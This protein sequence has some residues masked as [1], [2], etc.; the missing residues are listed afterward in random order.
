MGIRRLCVSGGAALREETSVPAPGV[1]RA[2]PFG[3]SLA[4][5]GV[6][7]IA[8]LSVLWLLLVP[9]TAFGDS[10]PN[11]SLRFGPSANLPDC[12]AYE[13]VSPAVK[14]DNS[15]LFEIHGFADGEHV[16][17]GSVLP[18]PGAQS[19][20]EGE[21]LSSRTPQ[22]WI[23]TPLS[24]PAGPGEPYG[25]NSGK[26][27]LSDS[28][29]IHAVSFTSDFS[30]AFVNSPMQYGSLDQNTQWNMFRVD[31]PSGA[32]F[33]ESLPDGGPM[34]EALIDP[35]N[36]GS[37]TERGSLYYTPGAFIAGNSA[38]GSRVFFETTVKLPVAA[39]SP[40]DTHVGG[41]ELFERHAGH[42]YLVGVLPDGS[43]PACGAEIGVFGVTS[44]PDKTI[45]YITG[46][47]WSAYG[48]VS[49][50]GS[51]VVFH[52]PGGFSSC[53]TPEPEK[54]YLRV[55]NGQPDAKT[56]E[57]PGLFLG[58]TADQTK[59]LLSG[60]GHL[61]EYD[62]PS[63]QTITVGEGIS[64][65]SFSGL[66]AYSADGSRVYSSAGRG[67]G[68]PF[69]IYENGAT[70]STPIPPGGVQGRMAPLAAPANAPVASRDGS[71]LVFVDT[72]N[73]TSYDSAGHREVYVYD[74]T[75]NKI[76]C[77]SCNPDGSAPKRDSGL[78]S[79]ELEPGQN[80]SDYQEG[81]NQSTNAFTRNDYPAVSSD[82][83]HVFFD[84]KEG[85]VPQDTN[86]LEDVYEW[87]Q[88]GIGTC[89]PSNSNY[90]ALSGGCVYLISSGTGSNGSWITGASEDGGNVFFVS[91]DDLSPNVV[92]NAQEIYDARI[93]GGFPYTP[94]V[95]GCDSGQ[96]QGP[97]TPAPPLLAPP[98]SATFVGVGN[99]VSGANAKAK[100]KTARSSQ[101]QR[102][103][104]A[105]AVCRQ[106]RSR[107]R[108]AV[109]ERRARHGYHAKASHGKRHS[110]QRGSK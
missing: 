18:V 5:L 68:Q 65:S 88:A 55:D 15:S 104:R 51:N 39:G 42:T 66:I 93:D 94:P 102:L 40:E 38:D 58:R 2:A 92:E 67:S 44:Q 73:L 29:L 36:V 50:D 64:E 31:I 53:S 34:T 45:W 8:I 49:A 48:A 22:G 90:S 52:S 41:N 20:E 59:L 107:R 24:V 78:L 77:I 76:L 63:G 19:G 95:Y 97:Q 11:A 43:V 6:A 99:V 32:V 83:A 75:G 16:W 85:L 84:S 4:V 25:F 70:R 100:P 71:R 47:N 10:C 80:Q 61:Y 7:F 96:C 82:D 26:N 27:S 14:A 28:P 33:I 62:I 89:G 60:E 37:T 23:T 109:C 101:G 98:P 86:G 72:E 79:E 35:P 13:L 12:R 17:F 108:R 106:D 87:E 74:A 54:T 110:N 57:L 103:A 46:S 21:S 1:G 69:L 91:N 105:L 3:V 56:I 81:L 9:V 30:A